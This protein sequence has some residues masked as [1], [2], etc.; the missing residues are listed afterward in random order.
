MM[1]MSSVLN[2]KR[3]N[4]WGAKIK[5]TLTCVLPVSENRRGTCIRCGQCCMLP[6]R[7]PF[8]KF[9]EHQKALCAI[10]KIRPLNCR[11]YPRVETEHV[12]G[13]CGHYFGAAQGRT[14]RVQTAAAVRSRR[15]DPR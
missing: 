5:R 6:N 7:C 14:R 15:K 10:Y 2:G 1:E 8:L 9:D 3:R 11:K 4:T 12:V 13:A